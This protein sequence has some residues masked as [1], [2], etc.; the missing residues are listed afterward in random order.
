[1]WRLR[2]K[3]VLIVFIGDKFRILSTIARCSGGIYEPVI[4]KTKKWRTERIKGDLEDNFVQE[5]LTPM[6]KCARPK[7][8]DEKRWAWK[9]LS[10]DQTAF[11]GFTSVV[12]LV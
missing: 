2:H 11:T 9:C 5:Y 7:S 10:N 4:Q 8:V 6:L 1:M 12:D 3:P